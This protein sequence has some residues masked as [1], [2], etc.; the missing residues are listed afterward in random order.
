MP[1]IKK[2]IKEIALEE[3]STSS[4]FPYWKGRV[5]LYALLKAMKVAKDD[6]VIMPAYTC[7]V[8]ANAILYL[9]AKPIYIDVSPESYNMDISKVKEAVTDRTKVIICQNTYG[10]STDLEVL[11]TIAKAN[12]LFTIEDCTHGYGGTYNGTPNGLSC[13]AAIYS[14]QWNKPFSTGIGGFSITKDKELIKSLLILNNELIQPSFKELVNIRILYSVKR[15]LIN[16][17]NYWPMINAYRWLSKNNLVVGSS[18]G[19]EIASIEI[20][21]AYFKAFS[22]IQA[23]EG[24]RNLPKLPSDLKKR[25]ECAH[26]YTDFLKKSGKNH[27]DEKWFPNHSFLKYPL[28]VNNRDDF[29]HLAEKNRIKLGEWFISPLHPVTGD[30][31]AWQFD[32]K[33]FPVAD[34]LATHVVNLP[35]SDLD[36]DKVISF[37]KKYSDFIIDSKTS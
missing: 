12:N 32:R 23:K 1:S 18:S 14:T 3:S 16:K 11:Q 33:Q 37:L 28:L 8:V 31:S 13:D 7:V 2:F 22:N 17:Y 36:F 27:V 21:K 10:L 29:M 35:T 24:L 34:Y 9:G 26:I 5:A 20:P 15:Y 25:K 6:E 19:G 4:I 30:L